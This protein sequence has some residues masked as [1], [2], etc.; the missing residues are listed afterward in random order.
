MATESELGIGAI[1]KP[2]SSKAPQTFNQEN[3]MTQ[4]N[5]GHRDTKLTG[6]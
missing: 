5:E 1:P 4:I 6:L 3:N 2:I